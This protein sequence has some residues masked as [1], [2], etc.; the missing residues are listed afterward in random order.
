M[1]LLNETVSDW[2][3]YHLTGALNIP[4]SI[5]QFDDSKEYWNLK[6]TISN[7]NGDT[8]ETVFKVYNAL[9]HLPTLCLS[10]AQDLGGLHGFCYDLWS[11]EPFGNCINPNMWLV[12]LTSNITFE[13]VS[14]T[15]DSRYKVIIS[16]VGGT[17][18]IHICFDDSNPIGDY[19]TSV[20]IEADFPLF[21]GTET[22]YTST[23]YDAKRYNYDASV[24][25]AYMSEISLAGDLT[26]IDECI[27]NFEAVD[28]IPRN[29][30]YFIR[31]TLKKNGAVVESKHYRFRIPPNARIWFVAEQH[32]NT[33][34]SYNMTLHARGLGLPPTFLWQV[35]GSGT[36][37]TEG[38]IITPTLG[39]YYY[40]TWTDFGTGDLYK[41]VGSSKAG[42]TNIPVFASEEQGDAYGDGLI[43]ADTALNSGD[44]GL[45]G[46][47]TTGNDLSSSDIPNPV[48]AGSGA[49]VNVWLLDKGNLNALFSILY[50]DTQ[51]V[52]DDI[53]KG[54]WLW[55]NNPI[56]FIVSI[57]YVPFDVSNFYDTRTER[58]WL[59]Q[60]DTG[61]DY[62]QCKETKSSGQRITLVNTTIDNVYGDFRDIDFF[63]YDLF[64]PYVGFVPLDPNVYVGHSLKIEMAFDVMSHNIRYY[65]F[66]DDVVTDRIDG[67]VGYAIPITGTDQVN[68]AQARLNGIVNTVKGGAELTGAVSTGNIKMGATGAMDMLNGVIEGFKYPKEIIRGDISSSM[69][70]YDI[71]YVYL[72]ITEKQ[73]IYPPEIRQIYNNP[74]YVVGTIS[75]LH[76][77]CEIDNIQLKSNCTESEY[78]EIIN[79]LKGGVII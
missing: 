2:S 23:G 67:S 53:K 19:S 11:F 55:G 70:I 10:G 38:H 72:K 43:G 21:L 78:N 17:D 42:N 60:Y 14:H 34:Q 24:Q 64:L 76:G 75:N 61:L 71:N 3:S 63:K 51:S 56:D 46:D 33:G 27:N 39:S 26:N 31:N 15:G 44:L 73:S 62:T 48:I 29:E 32:D 65:L 77:Y 25:G 74:C 66:C 6:I 16:N 79:L 8:Y 54:T 22:D 49:G 47:I 13:E 57:Y 50:D 20:N 58:V 36:S 18:W 52:I 59:G 9:N 4:N 45:D 1:G 41:V 28:T 5:E 37:W 30:I 12:N 40:G 68:K 69:N 35:G 7:T